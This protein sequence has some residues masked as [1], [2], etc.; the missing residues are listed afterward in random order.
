[1]YQ[2]IGVSDGYGIGKIVVISNKLP[3]C[4]QVMGLRTKEEVMKY[5]KKVSKTI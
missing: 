2:G 3:V 4:E 1:M 5:L